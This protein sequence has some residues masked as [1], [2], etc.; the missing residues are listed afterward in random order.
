MLYLAFTPRLAQFT[1]LYF[2]CDGARL[3]EVEN[4]DK[5]L[6]IYDNQW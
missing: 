3:K 5:R 2:T 6:P 4:I 1:L